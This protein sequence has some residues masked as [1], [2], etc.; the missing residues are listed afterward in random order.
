MGASDLLESVSYGQG[1][2][3]TATPSVRIWFGVLAGAGSVG[4][5]FWKATKNAVCNTRRSAIGAPV[6]RP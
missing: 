5:M 1:H 6:S 3:N 4:S 2:V